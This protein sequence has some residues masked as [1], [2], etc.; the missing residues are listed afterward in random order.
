MTRK[1]FDGKLIS[2]VVDE[3]GK[4]IVRHPDA[5]AVVA[6]D[7]DG[8]VALVRQ[9]R[10]AADTTLLEL[11]AGMLEEGEWPIDCARRELREETGLQ[12]G[13]WR[14]VASVFTTPGFCDERVHLF[15]ATGLEEG[16]PDPDAG[17]E[18][19]V[20]RVPEAALP[21][22]LPELQDAKTL[23]GLLLYLRG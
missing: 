1:A 20:V 11:P 15:V 9:Q 3:D 18:L 22:L 2:V 19:E 4:E 5:V 12:G 10:P 23:A 13:E 16:E 8:C 17:E 14:E 6:V 7:A 21:G